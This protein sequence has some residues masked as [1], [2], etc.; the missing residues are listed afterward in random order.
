MCQITETRE[1]R[2]VV[3]AGA[4]PAGLLCA[5]LLLERNNDANA[6]VNYHVTL[7]DGRQDFGALTKDELSKSFRSWMLGLANHGLD[8][9]RELPEL[10]DNYVKG[11]GIQLEELSIYL[12]SKRLNQGSVDDL[13]EKNDIPEAFIVDRNYIVAAIARYVKEKYEK[14]DKFKAM[15][16]TTCQYVDYENKQVLVRNKNTKEERYVPYDLLIGCDG[17]RSTVREALIRRHS[18]FSCTITDIFQEFKAVHVDRP[19]CI[20]AKGMSLLPDIF[21]G[22]QGIALPE[23][24]GKVNIS[25]GVPRHL[26]D[27]IDADLKSEDYRVVSK[28]IKEHFK[29]F[30]LVDYDDFAKQWVNQRWN[31]TGMVHCNFYHSTDLGIV[32]MGDAAHATSPSI[33]MGMNTALRDAQIFCHILRE[34]NDNLAETLEMYSKER[35]KEGNSLTSLAYNLYCHEKRPQTIETLH[36]IIRSILHKK[37]PWLVA[38][39][40]QNMI[41]LRGV[42]LSDVYDHATKLGIVSKHRLINERVR[43]EY[44]EKVSGMVKDSPK[45]YNVAAR[46]LVVAGFVGLSSV[47]LGKFFN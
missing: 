5:S 3:I 44:F 41:G 35:V 42:M 22:F 25:C 1:T 34:N 20:S 38:E 16:L 9:L 12:G 43:N 40:P 10:Y 37:L 31:Q 30:E 26:F 29:A 46:T 36:L 32:L 11:E 47:M 18:N 7:V 19:D 17:V 21:P 13:S 39:H 8:A 33:G 15:Y 14:H 28:Y 6:R 2:R 4:G 24:G 45:R 27:D 23:T